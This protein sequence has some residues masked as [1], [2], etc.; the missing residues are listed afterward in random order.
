M[1]RGEKKMTPTTQ[2]DKK[3]IGEDELLSFDM[4]LATAST[5]TATAATATTVTVVVA[6]DTSWLKLLISTAANETVATSLP[7]R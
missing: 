7:K 2:H 1:S 4:L 5:A 6:Y 3:R